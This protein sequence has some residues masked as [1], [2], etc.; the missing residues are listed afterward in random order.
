MRRCVKC[1]NNNNNKTLKRLRLLIPIKP[2]YFNAKQICIVSLTRCSEILDIRIASGDHVKVS[3]FR[4]ME[5]V[6]AVGLQIDGI[7]G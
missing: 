3:A 5:N 7:N 6:D 1:L 2:E 4:T